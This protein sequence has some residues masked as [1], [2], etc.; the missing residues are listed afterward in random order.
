MIGDNMYLFDKLIDQKVGQSVEVT[1]IRNGEI[2]TQSVPVNDVEQHKVKK[3]ALFAGG[4][5]L[6]YHP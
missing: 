5:I 1:V 6:I 4:N 3:F 2:V